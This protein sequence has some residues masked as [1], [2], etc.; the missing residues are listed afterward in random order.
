[1]GPMGSRP[2]PLRERRRAS[3]GP[4]AAK[5]VAPLTDR[6]RVLDA[7][8]GPQRVD[9]A[10]DLQLRTSADIALED[11]VVIAE[12]VDHII[13]PVVAEAEALAELAID[14]EQAADVLVVGR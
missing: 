2:A 14:A 7:V 9:A 8:L 3:R 10:G 1:M 5:D 4:P 6:R 11:L 12:M 13:S